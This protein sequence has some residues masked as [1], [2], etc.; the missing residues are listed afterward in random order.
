MAISR[1]R[2]LSIIR[3]SVTPTALQPKP[4]AIVSDCFPQARQEAKQ[5]SVFIAMRGKIPAS[6]M[7]VNSGKKIAIGG[8]MT[9]I[10]HAV[11]RSPP[12]IS[13]PDRIG[14]MCSTSAAY[15]RLS[16]SFINRCDSHSDG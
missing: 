6:S 15:A 7:S 2:R 12:S 13:A 11:P 16:H 9:E 10:T 4:I 1:S 3:L 8:S 14:G 5:R